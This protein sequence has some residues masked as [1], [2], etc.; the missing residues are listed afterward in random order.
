MFEWNVGAIILIDM[1]KRI[2]I[3]SEAD[4][5]RDIN[6][7]PILPSRLKGPRLNF[8]CPKEKGTWLQFRA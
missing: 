6:H 7:E 2:L 8:L 4:G 1:G 5:S 3:W